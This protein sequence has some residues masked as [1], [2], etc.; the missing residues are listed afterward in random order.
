M[1]GSTA[2]VRIPE[3]NRESKL[4]PKSMKGTLVGYND[5]GYRISVDQQ[6][7]VSR[8]VEFIEKNEGF[9]RIPNNEFENTDNET[10]TPK[11][12][13]KNETEEDLVTEDSHEEDSHEESKE[14]SDTRPKRDIKKPRWHRE[15]S[16]EESK[17]ESDTRP[18]RDIKKPRWHKEFE[19]LQIDMVNQ[20]GDNETQDE[21][22]ADYFANIH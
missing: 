1:Y 4:S 3:V 21:F 5:M 22:E 10:N 18:K 8:H 15:D 7:I 12:D 2:F 20:I 19:Q 13:E 16:H 17:E 11:E 6:I 9:V 14:E